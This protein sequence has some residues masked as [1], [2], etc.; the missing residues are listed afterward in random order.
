MSRLT[1]MARRGDPPPPPGTV[2][3][4]SQRSPLEPEAPP[5]PPPPPPS[6]DMPS[7]AIE[8]ANMEFDGEQHETNVDVNELLGKKGHSDR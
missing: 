8:D 5:P 4:L 2:P 1:P 6:N 3:V 7:L